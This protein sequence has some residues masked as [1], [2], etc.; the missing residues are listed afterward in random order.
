MEK[1][2]S[3]SEWILFAQFL[4]MTTDG[5]YAGL[6]MELAFSGRKENW[7]NAAWRIFLF[8]IFSILVYL[9]SYLLRKWSGAG[10]TLLINAAGMIGLIYFCYGRKLSRALFWY[11]IYL[12]SGILASVVMI[13]FTT[14]E[15]LALFD[16][17]S[18]LDPQYF[19]L[20]NALSLL[21]RPSLVWLVHQTQKKSR[22]TVDRILTLMMIFVPVIVLSVLLMRLSNHGMKLAFRSTFLI[23][24]IFFLMIVLIFITFRSRMEKELEGRRKVIAFQDLYYE[25]LQKR[26][27]ETEKLRHD[28]KNILLTVQ[29]LILSGRQDQA[30]EI[31]VNILSELDQTDLSAPDQSDD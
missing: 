6:M 31:L 12:V 11:L 19:A 22:R 30:R 7:K 23:L 27:L 8:W 29:S 5:I 28:Y 4:I 25:T 2:M 9:P 26:D 10:L 1:S 13:S 17:T 14:D 3:Q 24:I 15:R 18:V 20:G 16:W 21:I